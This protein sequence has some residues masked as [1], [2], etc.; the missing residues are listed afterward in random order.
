MIA[1]AERRAGESRA[2]A[3]G[4]Q[5]TESGLFVGL[6]LLAPDAPKLVTLEGT[7]Y[8]VPS[9]YLSSSEPQQVRSITLEEA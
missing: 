5:A 2:V 3:F 9:A 7:L 4:T 8:R 1:S 6:L